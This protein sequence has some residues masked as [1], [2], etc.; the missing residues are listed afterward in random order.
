[1][2]QTLEIS[3]TPKQRKADMIKILNL[4]RCAEADRPALLK[5]AFEVFENLDPKSETA[6]EEISVC[7]GISCS[8]IRREIKNVDPRVV[9]NTLTKWKNEVL[10]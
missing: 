9:Q 7:A 5:A 3:E 10:K 2:I 8:T 6:L 4:L 1:M